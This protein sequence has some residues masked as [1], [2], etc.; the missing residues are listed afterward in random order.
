MA[1]QSNN[2]MLLDLT[3]GRPRTIDTGSD[4]LEIGVDVSLTGGSDLVVS[5]NLTV[6]GTMTVVESTVVNVA[7]SH[8]FMASNYTT[9]VA[10]E[11][12]I[13]VNYLPTAVTDT[14]AATGFVAGS[15]G[16]SNPTVNTTGAA[17]FA[18]GDV[19]VITDSNSAENTGL[20]EVLSH[21]ANLLTIRG[22]GTAGTTFNFFQNQFVTD[23]V[24][25]GDITQVNVSVL[26]AGTDGV[27][28]VGEGDNTGSITFADLATTAGMTLTSAYLAGS[29]LTTTGGGGD[30]TFAG[31]EEFVVSTS[32]GMQVDNFLNL[33]G[34]AGVELT[35]AA[36]GLA[37]GQLIQVNTSGEAAL[38]DNNTGTVS[39][40]FCVGV[41]TATFVAASTAQIH[42][43]Q[44]ALVP[45]L[46]AAAPAAASNGSEVFLD[47]TAGRA[48]LT[49]PSAS[50]EVVFAV[51]ILQGATGATATPAVLFMPRLVAVIP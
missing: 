9:A 32:G 27:F 15:A 50:G 5:G 46:F 34:T 8:L 44:G 19:I 35:A 30:V 41:S 42:T 22:I 45:M 31:S 36:G 51:G 14:V 49:A 2:M 25:A 43:V 23:T 18:A 21:A 38:A 12:G 28:E 11:G 17:T 39:D 37:T 16:V 47:S 10:R 48:T 26:Q 24:V 29:T 20:F 33:A 1:V 6:D 4:E 40:S 13:A 3:N 7:D